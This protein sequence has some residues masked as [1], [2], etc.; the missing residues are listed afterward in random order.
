M[1]AAWLLQTPVPRMSRPLGQ[2]PSRMDALDGPQ[3]TPAAW[4]LVNDAPRERIASNA[5]S[6]SGA[7][8]AEFARIP[9]FMSSRM[10]SRMFGCRMDASKAWRGRRWTSAGAG[11]RQRAAPRQR[12]MRKNP[13]LQAI[14]LAGAAAAR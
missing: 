8:V 11:Q 4:A 7:G 6:G 12:D 3:L 5:G 1:R 13:E 14:G 9:S 2:R 10:S